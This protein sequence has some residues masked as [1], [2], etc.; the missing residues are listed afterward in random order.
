MLPAA[1]RAPA[2]LDARAVGLRN[3]IRPRTQLILEQSPQPPRLRHRQPARLG[4]RAADDIRDGARFGQREA[5]RRQA[6][7][8]LPHIA[9]VD[10]AVHQILIGRHSYG[11]VAVGPCQVAEDT[12]LF[13][14]EIS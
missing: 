4:A 11:P 9:R 5:R 14:R 10:P 12:H 1:I 6:F 8:E 7:I 2:D 13:A 3:Q